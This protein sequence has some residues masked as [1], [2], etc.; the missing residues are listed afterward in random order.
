MAALVEAWITL[1]SKLPLQYFAQ[2]CGSVLERN[3]GRNVQQYNYYA[4]TPEAQY[5]RALLSRWQQVQ[6]S[7]VKHCYSAIK[8]ILFT[9]TAM[10]RMSA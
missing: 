10:C 5:S 6:D 8:Y 4:W 9:L 1:E 3:A 2:K 7:T